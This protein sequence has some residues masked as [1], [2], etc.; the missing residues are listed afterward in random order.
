MINLNET[1]R[2]QDFGGMVEEKR[3]GVTKYQG[4]LVPVMTPHGPSDDFEWKIVVFSFFGPEEYT[5]K[6]KI[7][8][9]IIHS[10]DDSY[11][12]NGRGCADL[13]IERIKAAGKIDLAHW[14]YTE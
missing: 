10:E 4:D 5:L 3:W 1:I 12:V 8:G 9:R 6:T 14:D 13:M 11:Y 2:C 7:T